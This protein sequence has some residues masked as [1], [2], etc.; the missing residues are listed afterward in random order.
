MV[1]FNNKSKPKTEVK[2]NKQNTFD[3]VNALYEG[4]E[5]TL[6][7]FRSRIFPIKATYSKGS[8]RILALRPLDLACVAKVFDL[9][10][11]KLL[12]LLNKCFKDYQ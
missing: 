9:K 8:P 5:L 2:A 10:R 4:Q 7:A 6:K 11:L 3:S 1:K 12:T